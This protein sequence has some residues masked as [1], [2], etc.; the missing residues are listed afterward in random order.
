[1]TATRS[2]L[3]LGFR[4]ESPLGLAALRIALALMILVSPELRQAP[5][6]AASARALRFVPEGLGWA[7]RHVPIQPELARAAQLLLVLACVAAIFGVAAR[8]ALFVV[9]CSGLYVF[10]LSQ[11]SGAVIHDMTFV[12]ADCAAGGESLCGRIDLARSSRAAAADGVSRLR[13]ATAVRAHAVGHR[14]LLPR[15]LEAADFGL[16]LDQQRQLAQPAVLEA[17]TSAAPRPPGCGWIG[18]RACCTPRRLRWCCSS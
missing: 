9:T 12:V 10:G 1:M 3:M 11:L 7:V 17:G 8:L 5:D 2:A 6:F 13:R 16:G 4:A 18:Y 15:L 14:L